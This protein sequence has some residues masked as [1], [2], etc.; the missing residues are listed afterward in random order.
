MV[1]GVRVR[2]RVRVRV[3][4][5]VYVHICVCVRVHMCVCV[6]LKYHK[7]VLRFPLQLSRAQC[8]F[9]TLH[10]VYRIPALSGGS[11]PVP[12]QFSHLLLC[13]SLTILPL[14]QWMENAT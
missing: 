9:Y 13:W 12:N 3:Y 1:I 2:V 6:W 14:A 8:M 10:V 5:R 7:C 4:V 11:G